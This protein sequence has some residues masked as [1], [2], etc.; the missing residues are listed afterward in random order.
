M[1]VFQVL[2]PVN[3]LLLGLCGVRS[4]NQY[5]IHVNIQVTLYLTDFL[6]TLTFVAYRTPKTAENRTDSVIH[7][8]LKLAYCTYPVSGRAKVALVFTGVTV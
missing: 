6:T 7:W 1:L 5:M 3:L 2:L 4:E 8:D